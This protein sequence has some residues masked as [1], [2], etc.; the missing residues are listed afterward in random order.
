MRK[1]RSA[2]NYY[3]DCKKYNLHKAAKNTTCIKIRIT[4]N[5]LMT[6]YCEGTKDTIPECHKNIPTILSR[7]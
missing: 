5:I 7:K 3:Q 1:W 6:K 4:Q 2:F